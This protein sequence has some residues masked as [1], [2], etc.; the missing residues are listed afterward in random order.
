ML[1]VLRELQEPQQKCLRYD[2]P[3]HVIRSVSCPYL[4]QS[5][6]IILDT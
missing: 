2:L 4:F 3:V 5:K 6:F 1:V